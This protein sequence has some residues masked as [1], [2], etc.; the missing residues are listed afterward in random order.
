MSFRMKHITLFNC[1]WLAGFFSA[2]QKEALFD[3]ESFRLD[4]VTCFT[5]N[6]D[7]VYLQSDD[8]TRLFP[9]EPVPAG[10]YQ[11]G[12]RVMLNYVIREPIEASPK[13]YL[14]KIRSV[15][16]VLYAEITVL[17]PKDAEAIGNDPLYLGSVWYGGECI[18]LRYKI[19]FNRNPHRLALIYI[20]EEQLPDDTLRLQ[21]KHDRNNDPDGFL[22]SGYASFRLPETLAEQHRSTARIQMNGSNTKTDF[23]TIDLN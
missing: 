16:P 23:F 4:M 11:N 7:N 19:E 22:V 5:D 15:K 9:E 10:K 8:G 1:L 12:Q 21:L 6:Q 13:S 2:C 14:I 18:N 3:Y 20:P 17:S